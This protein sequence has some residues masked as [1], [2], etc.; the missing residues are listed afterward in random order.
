MLAFVALASSVPGQR[1]SAQSIQAADET[2]TITRFDA[3]NGVNVQ[4]ELGV[5]A[6][7]SI[8]GTGPYFTSGE[9]IVPPRDLSSA[10]PQSRVFPGLAFRGANPLRN[11][12]FPAIPSHAE[13]VALLHWGSNWKTACERLFV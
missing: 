4:R 1:C 3:V 13:Q 6:Q 10:F 7:P 8:P 12:G 5:P 2:D 11:C 9:V